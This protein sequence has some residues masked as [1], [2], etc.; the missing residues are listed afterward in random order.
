KNW[1]IK[2]QEA[3]K[4]DGCTIEW[5]NYIEDSC[6]TAMIH[7]LK[8]SMARNCNWALIQQMQANFQQLPGLIS[9]MKSLI[10]KYFNSA[11]DKEIATCKFCQ[12]KII[13]KFGST[14]ALLT[15]LMKIHWVE[16]A[17]EIE[18]KRKD[19]EQE[20]KERDMDWNMNWKLIPKITDGL[21][22]LD[23][24]T[25]VFSDRQATIADV[26]PRIN[27]LVNAIEE[28]D[29]QSGIKTMMQ[30]LREKVLQQFFKI[31][32]EK[33]H[34]TKT[35]ALDPRYKGKMFKNAS[36]III[37]KVELEKMVNDIAAKN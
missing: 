20:Q 26:I 21:K 7:K 16:Y 34:C 25:N 4:Q 27:W 33:Y 31:E 1:A 24:L 18:P 14:S 10:Y 35:T 22:P 29:E 17:N 8:R 12:K 37:V 23:D 11:Q 28:S 15:Q 2:N 9:R 32:Q 36:T 6:N 5:F 3:L 13:S 30:S 19:C